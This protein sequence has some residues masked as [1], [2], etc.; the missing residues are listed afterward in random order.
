MPTN[1]T[2]NGTSFSK[3]HR[4][5]I[6]TSFETPGDIGI[7][8]PKKAKSHSPSDENITWDTVSAH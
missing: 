2:L 8:H 3:Y 7:S 5:R 4:Q 1:A 6:A